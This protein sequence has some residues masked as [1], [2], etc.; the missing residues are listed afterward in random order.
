MTREERSDW[1]YRLKSEIVVFMPYKWIDPMD[2]ALTYAIKLVEQEQYYK[3]LAESYEKTINKLTKAIAEQEPKIN[4]EEFEE[5]ISRGCDYAGTQEVVHDTFL[6]CL[7]EL[8]CVGDWD[9]MSTID[10]NGREIVLQDL[11]ERFYDKVA[12]NIVNYAKTC[13]V[14][15]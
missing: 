12:R 10:L 1:L 3:D 13:E 11:M 2:E 8:G 5:G 4:L 15:I 14:M 7:N 6:E 9:E